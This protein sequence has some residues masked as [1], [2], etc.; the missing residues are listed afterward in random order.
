MDLKK[1]FVKFS[2]W[3]V[4][5]HGAETCM[6]MI[7]NNRERLEAFEMEVSMQENVKDQLGRQSNK[8]TSS[9]DSARNRSI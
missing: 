9:P 7:Q 8:Y 3:N 6:T 2:M 1:G 5:L 4:P